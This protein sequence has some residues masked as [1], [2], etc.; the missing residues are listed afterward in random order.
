MSIRRRVYLGVGA[1]VLVIAMTVAGYLLGRGGAPDAG[2]GAR[3]R[4]EATRETLTRGKASAKA[5][6]RGARREGLARGRRRGGRAG[7]QEG[8]AAGQAAVASNGNGPTTLPPPKL[9]SD[10]FNASPSDYGERPSELIVG[11]HSVLDDA[12]WSSWG[13]TTASGSATL[14]GVECEPSCAEGPETRKQ[15]RLEA[16]EP[17]FSP[18][19]IRYYA[20]LRI[21]EASGRAETVEIQ[22][23]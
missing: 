9:P 2:D 5:V 16:V 23:G 19:N 22:G 11:N 14:V 13:G 18:D 15:V 12:V 21:I 17:Q 7:T 8:D 4:A 1:A 20:R 6:L 10:L 3:V